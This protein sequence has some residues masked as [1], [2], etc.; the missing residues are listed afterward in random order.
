MNTIK[1]VDFNQVVR[2]AVTAATA[3]VQGSATEVQ[4]I[5]ENSAKGLVNDV[6]FLAKKKENGE[7]DEDDARVYMDDQKILARVRLR[8]V[9]I[10]TLQIAERVW[11]AIA[12]LF[13]TAINN[14]LG[15]I[16][17]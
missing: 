9:A 6:A 3:I 15:W 2:D 8:S 13:R 14:A 4:D 16:V 7:F 5:V 10:I 1:S 17:I 11:N 12:N